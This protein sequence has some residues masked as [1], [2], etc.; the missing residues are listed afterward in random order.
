VDRPLPRLTIAERARARAPL[1]LVALAL[2]GLAG[3]LASLP[4]KLPE[5]TWRAA[6]IGRV[7]RGPM[8]VQIRAPGVLKPLHAR[9]LTSASGGWVEAVEV[10]PGR[11]V[12]KDAVLLRLI[13]PAL[14]QH[15]SA[16]R[17]TLN[18]ARAQALADAVEREAGL[19]DLAGRIA[20]LDGAAALA[21]IERDARDTLAARG[22]VSALEQRRAEL[23]A[24]DKR[25]QHRLAG[26]RRAAFERAAAASAQAATERLAELAQNLA[27][28]SARVA[29][30]TL[31]APFA[32]VVS[33]LQLEPG[34]R[35]EPGSALLRLVDPTQFGAQLK[36]AERDASLLT[37]GQR[38]A[39]EFAGRTL[40]G[41]V[42]RIDFS[43]RA[44]AV[45]VDIALDE[46]GVQGGLSDINIEARITLSERADVL[47]VARPPGALANSAGGVY[48]LDADGRRAHRVVVRFGSASFDQ[49]EIVSGLNPGD[50]LLLDGLDG[51]DDA[52]TIALS[53]AET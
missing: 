22:I 30:L 27:D 36:V 17:S 20:E 9:W 4:L 49:I 51:L 41:R 8:T 12:A 46:P 21:E 7:E 45:A 18:A 47:R 35:V 16:A 42:A 34:Q 33:E 52:P 5:V 11:L 38:A 25:V 50:R 31:R 26:E 14:E 24:R 15:S 43:V 1:L 48:R 44:G 6:S 23:N 37:I 3:W 29:A 39:V 2:L 13:E 40:A 53:A 32:G 28:A 19:I 10:E